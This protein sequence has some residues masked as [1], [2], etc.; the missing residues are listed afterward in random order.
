MP[1]TSRKGKRPAPG[2]GYTHHLTPVEQSTVDDRYYYRVTAEMKAPPLR[3]KERIDGVD[4]TVERDGVML[5]P[6][7]LRI[8]V[9]VEPVIAKREG[10]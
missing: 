3:P 6:E 10:R 2:V 4:V 9:R 7:T 5:D 1:P 8:P